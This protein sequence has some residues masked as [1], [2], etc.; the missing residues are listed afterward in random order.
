MILEGLV[1][2]IRCAM[3]R[4]IFI[5]IFCG[6]RSTVANTVSALKLNQAHIK[7]DMVKEIKTSILY[8][9]LKSVEVSPLSSVSSNKK[10]RAFYSVIFFD[11]TQNLC[12]MYENH[13]SDTRKKTHQNMP[14]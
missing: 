14:E 8:P 5:L 7:K 11:T 12:E 6:L 3:F 4:P 2:H 10:R 9:T 13:N 1:I